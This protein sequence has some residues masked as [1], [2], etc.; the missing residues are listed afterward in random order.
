M[1][2]YTTTIDEAGMFDVMTEATERINAL[3]KKGQPFEI[4]RTEEP[5]DL[6]S[7]PTVM[8]STFHLAF[9]GDAPPVNSAAKTTAFVTAIV[10][11]MEE[12][13]RLNA[14][15]YVVVHPPRYTSGK[16]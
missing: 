12:I 1:F 9:T 8:L 16:R 10:G 6:D 2:F 4:M 13:Q 11:A 7:M 14:S 15:N 5:V 3:V